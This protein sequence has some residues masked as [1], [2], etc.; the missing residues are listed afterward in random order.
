[1]KVFIRTVTHYY[2]GVVK[3][4]DADEWVLVQAAWIADTGR[5]SVAVSK[6]QLAEVEPYPPDV[7]VHI[8][9]RQEVDWS[10]WRHPL[11]KAS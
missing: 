9:R 7:Q 1:M 3:R 10:E 11:P 8:N 2:V 6:G 4:V 5:F